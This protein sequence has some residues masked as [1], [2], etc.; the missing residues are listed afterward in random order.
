[1]S[2][3]LVEVA[4]HFARRPVFSFSHQPGELGDRFGQD[5][6]L[7]L[8]RLLHVK[9]QQALFAHRQHQPPPQKYSDHRGGEQ[10]CGL[11]HRDPH[12]KGKPGGQ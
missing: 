6:P 4:A 2:D 1:M 8:L 7:H 3:D 10:V 5:H 9:R 11:A 12:P